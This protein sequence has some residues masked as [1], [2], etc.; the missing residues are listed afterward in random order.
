MVVLLLTLQTMT[1][2]SSCSAIS[3]WG[4]SVTPRSSIG[5]TLENPQNTCHHHL[6]LVISAL[7][8]SLPTTTT[9]TESMF[10]CALQRKSATIGRLNGM[11]R[12]RFIHHIGNQFYYS[13]LVLLSELLTVCLSEW[14]TG[15]FLTPWSPRRQDHRPFGPVSQNPT[16]SDPDSSMSICLHRIPSTLFSTLCMKKIL[17]CKDISSEATFRL[18]VTAYPSTISQFS[19]PLKLSIPLL[20]IIS[21]RSSIGTLHGIGFRLQILFPHP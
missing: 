17:S 19:Q 18:T 12:W 2:Q 5:K 14:Y 15:P 20:L 4:L 10:G 21:G 3:L 1:L 11:N 13:V 8:P 6:H 16:F 7:P 9:R